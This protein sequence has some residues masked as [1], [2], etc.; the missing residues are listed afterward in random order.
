MSFK[1]LQV[2]I[3]SLG[4]GGF[5]LF[6]FAK[7]SAKNRLFLTENERFYSKKSA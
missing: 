5:F 4:E 2:R 6:Y 1:R 7:K 3:C